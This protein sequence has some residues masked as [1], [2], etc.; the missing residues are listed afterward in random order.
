MGFC[1]QGLK[2]LSNRWKSVMRLYLRSA[3]G[4]AEALL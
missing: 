2:A 3:D 4:E 1:L